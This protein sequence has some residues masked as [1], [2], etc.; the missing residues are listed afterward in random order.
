LLNSGLS[1]LFTVGVPSTTLGILL[2]QF[3]AKCCFDWQIQHLLLVSYTF[4]VDGVVDIAISLT[5]RV[6]AL[7]ACGAS[8]VLN[9]GAPAV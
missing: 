7:L 6:T 8:V 1:S 3:E 5:F 2:G 9:C 4:T